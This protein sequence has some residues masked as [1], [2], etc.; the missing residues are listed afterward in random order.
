YDCCTI[1]SNRGIYNHIWCYNHCINN[2]VNNR[3]SHWLNNSSYSYN[4]WSYN[5]HNNSSYSYNSWSYNNSSYSYNSCS[6]NNHNN[7]SYSYNSCSYNNHN[8]SSY[9]YNYKGTYS[10][11][12]CYNHS[13]INN[14]RSNHWLNNSF[15]YCC[16]YNHDHNDWGH[17][18]SRNHNTLRYTD[19]SR[20]Y[21]N[22]HINTY[23]G[24][25]TRN[26]SSNQSTG[27]HNNITTNYHNGRDQVYNVTDGLGWCYIA[28][29]NATCKIDTQSSPCP[30]TAPTTVSPTTAAARISSTS[31][32]PTTL[33]PTPSTTPSTTTQDCIYVDPP[34]KNGE[35]W[36]VKNCTTAICTNGQVTE[37]TT[38]CSTVQQPICANGHKPVQVYDEDGCCFHY[39]CKCVCNVWD[40]SHYLTFDGKSY[41]FKESCSYYLV[42]E[43]TSKYN[44]TIILTNSDCGTSESDSCIKTLLI[45]YQSFSITLTQSKSSGTLVNEVLV[46]NKRV[47]PAYSNSVIHITGT[48]ITITLKIPAIGVQV[49]YRGSSFSID[50]SYSFFSGNT[51]GQCGTCDNSQTNDCRAPNGQVANCSDSA[52]Q[53]ED[54]RIPCPTFPPPTTAPPSSTTKLPFTTT[55]SPC[56]PAICDL[57]SSSV[58]E[59]C[60]S[61][62]SPEPF[63]K[64]C[65]SDVCEDG[66]TG[67]SSLQAYASECSNEGICI[68]WRNATNGQCEH[69]CPVDKVYKACGPAVEPTCDD[70][71]N[72]QFKTDNQ[73]LTNSSNTVEGCFCPEDTT[74]FNTVYH[75]CVKSC[76]CVGPNG[77]PR[78]PGDTWISDCEKCQCDNDTMS[79]LCEPIKCPETPGLNCSTTGEKVVTEIVDC[80]PKES[81]ECDVKLCP[82][83]LT[84][85]LGFKLNVT[86]ESGDCCPT[87]ECVPKGVCVYNM[88]EYKVRTQSVSLPQC[89][90]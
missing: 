88:T 16:V 4:S 73:P 25:F 47:Y 27:C 67:C 45:T 28:Y 72:K 79:V 56:K 57:L 54:P 46:N 63:I 10:H 80:C 15:Y 38:P 17:N 39:E 70:R 40:G 35:S 32:S 78:E 26:D 90:T 76:Y 81:C 84:C 19:T 60:Y 41:D 7:S 6:Y 85:S 1:N 75:E 66:K 11:I 42:K 65:K 12:W 51:E 30:T 13:W 53:W 23:S 8:N 3:S 55:V 2:N 71:Y 59:L 31:V 77:K 86:M 69:K 29:C 36:K 87:Y 61:A 62:V 20:E 74:L 49:D 43:I 68:D 9:S 48:D 33:V 21:D 58:F 34:R 64:T 37:M 18:R 5:N 22:V 24:H 52:G 44:L 14:N 89:V 83:A 50:L 82:G